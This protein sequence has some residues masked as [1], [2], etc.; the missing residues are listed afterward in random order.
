ML[1][2]RTE[3]RLVALQPPVEAA[4]RGGERPHEFGQRVPDAVAGD[5]VRIEG[6][7]QPGIVLVLVELGDDVRPQASHFERG[8]H[9]VVDLLL[10]GAGPTVPELL[11]VQPRVEHRGR[12][13]EAGLALDP[14]RDLAAVVAAGGQ[15]VAARAG[16][17]VVP[18]YPW[19]V[20]ERTA[21]VCLLGV[22]LDVCRDRL[23][24]LGGSR[25]AAGRGDGCGED[26][27]A[28]GEPRPAE[29]GFRQ[30]PPSADH[31]RKLTLS[32]HSILLV[33]REP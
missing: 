23:D 20:E 16:D 11:E 10:Q 24:G 32:L 13:D 25:A 7:E 8:L 27:D 30:P 22:H 6:L 3:G 12:V 17:G 4:V 15:N 31:G 19:I 26:D 9:R 14:D 33:S 2:Q 18:G 21:E 5:A 28:G 1:L 29:P